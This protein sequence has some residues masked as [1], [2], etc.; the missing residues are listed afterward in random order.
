MNYLKRNLKKKV[1]EFE[2]NFLKPLECVDEYLDTFNRKGMYNT[3]SEGANDKE[4]RWQAFI[5]F[6]NFVS[7]TL[8]NKDKKTQLK[9]KES[10]VGPIKNA[11]FKIIRKRSLGVQGTDLGKVHEFVRKLPKYLANEE[12]KKLIL[13]IKNVPENIPEELKYDKVGNKLSEREIDEKWG[14][15]NR[16]SI[17]GN[18]IQAHRHVH[19]QEER[20]KPLELLGDALKKLQHNNLKIENMGTEYYDLAL[21]VTKKIIAEA[22]FIFKAVDDARYKLKKLTKNKGK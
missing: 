17:L 10:E 21:D 16:E 5:D 4:G 20:D 9:I 19:N 14:A 7:G 6:S 1:K 18:L 12:A 11:V 13:E 22:E 8:H 15:D 2:K 3:I